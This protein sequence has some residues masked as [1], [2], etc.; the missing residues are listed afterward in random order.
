M[1]SRERLLAAL[2]RRPGDR[3]P[4]C[5]T[6]IWPETFERWH[7]EGLPADIVE[8]H[9]NEYFGLDPIACIN[10]L[11]E[12]SPGYEERLLSETPE[13]RVYV[14][15]Y[16]KTLKE[17]REGSHTPSIIEPAIKSPADWERMKAALTPSEDR[18][19]NPAAAA[20][21]QA[22]AAAGQFIAITPAEPLWFVIY[23]TMGYEVGLRAVAK[24]RKLVA[25][26]IATYTD[27]LLAMLE[28]TLARGYRFDALWF[29]SDLCYREGLLLSPKAVRELALPHWKRLGEFIR[30]QGMKFI[31]HCDGNVSQL[32][33]LLLE[34][35]VDA[36]HPLEARAGNDVRTLKPQYGDQ[37][38][39]I[40]NINA[41]IV[42]T[43]DPAA[44][45]AEVAAKIPVAAA[46]G[47][48]IYNIDHSVPPT[49][50][51]DTYRH[52]LACVRK[53]GGGA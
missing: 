45:E 34:A 35:G 24:D 11:F 44:I 30:S 3:I 7:G 10:D 40:G 20:Q 28:R 38:C 15:S 25:D 12:P 1:T 4:F 6:T 39:F 23:L 16:G 32:I 41:D 2:E 31:F 17:W 37:L 9:Y 43:N 52:L 19:N 22:A 14:D 21:Y 48:Y 18:F 27:Y 53:Y 46:G 51:L 49:V 5:E 47:G 13:Q 50:S 26:M 42:A 33:P 29:W 36:M 8:G